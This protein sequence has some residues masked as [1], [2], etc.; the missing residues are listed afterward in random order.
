M[1]ALTIAWHRLKACPNSR[2]KKARVLAGVVLVVLAYIIKDAIPK[3]K[4]IAIDA[5]DI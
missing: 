5:H 4:T 1:Y 3:H 2:H